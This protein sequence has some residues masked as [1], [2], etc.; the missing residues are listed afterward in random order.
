RKLPKLGDRNFEAMRAVP[1]SARG[2]RSGESSQATPPRDFPM[3]T[4]VLW[5]MAITAP[6]LVAAALWELKVHL[7]AKVPTEPK[8]GSDADRPEDHREGLLR[9]GVELVGPPLE[10][11][12]L[13]QPA[14]EGAAGPGDVAEVVAALA[15]A[16]RLARSVDQLGE[17]DAAVA[18]EHAVTGAGRRTD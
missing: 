7:A 15:D 3:H 9:V 17:A 4:L 13:E 1:F 2:L 10:R 6:L 18:V 8:V 12:G 5:S 11:R 16:E 14:A